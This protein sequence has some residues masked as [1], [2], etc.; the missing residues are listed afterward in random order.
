MEKK[1]YFSPHFSRS[2]NSI[3]E[4][5]V[6]SLIV[7]VGTILIFILFMF[8]WVISSVYINYYMFMCLLGLSVVLCV[9]CFHWDTS[10][11]GKMVYL[12]ELSLSL[13]IPTM[14]ERCKRPSWR[15]ERLKWGRYLHPFSYSLCVHRHSMDSND[16]TLWKDF[17]FFHPSPV[18]FHLHFFSNNF[19]RSSSIHIIV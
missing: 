12:F 5:W 18:I 9:L 13:H 6:R 10:P 11:C 19:I 17:T 2:F 8:W 7:S 16:H 1:C 3:E 14:V 4:N 15:K